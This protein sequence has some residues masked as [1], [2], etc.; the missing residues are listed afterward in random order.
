MNSFQTQVENIPSLENRVTQVCYFSETGSTNQEA[1][2][3]G[4]DGS[5]SGTL[6][7][8]EAQSAGHGRLGRPWESPPG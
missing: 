4:K 8:A 6:L 3:A 5:P 2:Q 7:I 1:M